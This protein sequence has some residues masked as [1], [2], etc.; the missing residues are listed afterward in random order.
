VPFTIVAD[1][2]VDADGR[3]RLRPASIKALGMPAKG[4][5]QEHRE[6][7]WSPATRR[8]LRQGLKVYMPVY[9]SLCRP[10]SP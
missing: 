1:P 8:T 3:L 5:L 9:A 2:S 6:R 4:C 10:R 7:S